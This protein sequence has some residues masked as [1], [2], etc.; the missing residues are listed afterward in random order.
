MQAWAEQCPARREG[1]HQ[2]DVLPSGNRRVGCRWIG[3][4]TLLIE[5]ESARG[6]ICPSVRSELILNRG[7]FAN[8]EYQLC[9]LL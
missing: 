2:R 8:V 7:H 3:H 4:L 6:R 9:P 1:S 5:S